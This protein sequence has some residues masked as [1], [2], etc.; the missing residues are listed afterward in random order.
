MGHFR[1]QQITIFPVG[2]CNMRCRYCVADHAVPFDRRKKIDLA[3]A[4][5]GIADYFGTGDHHQLRFY[6]GGEPTL[7]LDVIE[8]CCKFA[9]SLVGERLVTEIQTN[10]YFSDEVA[11]W[12]SKH[13]TIIWASID[14]W[15]EV[16]QTNRPVPGDRNAAPK[17]IANARR[18]AERT[19]VGIRCTIVPETVNKQVELLRYFLSEGFKVV[20]S[21]PE[22]SPVRENEL[23][24]SGPITQV[25]LRQYAENFVEAWHFAQEHGMTYFNSFMC[26]FDEPVDVYCRACLPTPHLTTDGFVSACDLGFCGTSPLNKLIYGRYDAAEDKID[27][28]ADAIELLRSRRCS[29]IPACGQCVAQKHCAGGCLGRSYHETRDFFGVIHD[30][31]WVTRYLF[32]RLPAGSVSLPYLHP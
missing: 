27:Y 5:R 23:R 30:Y 3:F 2:D 31:C 4:K 15:P 7:A 12:L 28:W 8:E 9:R 21:E 20:V 24:P 10:C 14:G 32:N 16:Q 29:N 22:F 18:M 17:I 13:M 26:N 19:F 25:D 1:K 11:F 6:S